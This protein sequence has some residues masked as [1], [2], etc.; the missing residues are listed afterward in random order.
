[1]KLW[2]T[3]QGVNYAVYILRGGTRK[4]FAR[5]FVPT[6]HGGRGQYLSVGLW[7]VAFYRGY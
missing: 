3:R 4:W 2:T 6:W 5:R 1:M 7:W